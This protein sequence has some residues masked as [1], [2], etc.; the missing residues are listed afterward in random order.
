ME[1]G[2]IAGTIKLFCSGFADRAKEGP[3][4]RST[5]SSSDECH[6]SRH[7]YLLEKLPSIHHRLPHPFIAAVI[8]KN[9][10]EASIF[11]STS[12]TKP[13]VND[14]PFAG[15]ATKI[16]KVWPFFL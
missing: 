9:D 15:A 2:C 16:E 3:G 12:M 11:Q 6:V 14:L 7:H 1:A 10:W 8:I 13:K 5:P 4:Q